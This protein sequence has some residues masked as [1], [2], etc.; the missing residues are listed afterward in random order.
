MG[1]E[2]F[3]S[4]PGDIH[5]PWEWAGVMTKNVRSH[6]LLPPPSRPPA[7]QPIRNPFDM[8]AG[9]IPIVVPGNTTARRSALDSVDADLPD[10]KEP[11]KEFEYFTDGED[12]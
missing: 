6:L 1:W 3:N 9:Q 7:Q 8:S 12:E 11:P 2:Y 5:R 10:V 4:L